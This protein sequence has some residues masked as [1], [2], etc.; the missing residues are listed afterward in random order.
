MKK[1][2]FRK[3][4][5]WYKYLF[6]LEK[7]RLHKILPNAKIEHVGSTSIT[8]LGGKGLIDIMIGLKKSNWKKAEKTLLKKKY[9]SMEN[10]SDWNRISLKKDYGFWPFKRRVHVHLTFINSPNWKETINFK[11]NLLKNP[12]LCKEYE[13]IK[14]EA[15]KKAK[16]EGNH[17]RAYKS[18]F[19]KKH[20]K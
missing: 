10:A 8:G 3:Y 15:V 5:F 7:K 2:V 20:S 1:Y 6:N 19:I 17:Y 4:K 9:L 18:K 11:N 12:K 16:G 14:K 13:I